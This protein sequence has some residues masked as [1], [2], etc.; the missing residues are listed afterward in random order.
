M[1][2]LI[3]L[4]KNYILPVALNIFPK[5]ISCM[6]ITK[7][8]LT[9]ASKIWIGDMGM[10][11]KTDIILTNIPEHVNNS[12]IMVLTEIEIISNPYRNANDNVQV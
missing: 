3:K 10:L 12:T 7:L 2:D 9:R 4:S 11:Y 8:Q 5:I 1:I 6:H